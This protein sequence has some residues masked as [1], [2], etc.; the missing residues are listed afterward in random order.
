MS[1]WPQKPPP[2]SRS[3]PSKD[4]ASPSATS[5]DDETP[6]MI[7]SSIRSHASRLEL[8]RSG[9]SATATKAAAACGSTLRDVPC[10]ACRTQ[11]VEMTG[12]P[13]ACEGSARRL[14]WKASV[15][16]SVN[17]AIGTFV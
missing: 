3:V 10:A 6:P 15:K 2:S 16:A 11:R 4:T 8:V 13:T 14:G 1:R 12:L 7:T 17:T 9:T 5:C